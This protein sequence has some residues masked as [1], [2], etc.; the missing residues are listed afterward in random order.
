MALDLMQQN[1]VIECFLQEFDSIFHWCVF[2]LKVLLAVLSIVKLLELWFP[3]GQ[4]SSLQSSK[5]STEVLTL[6]LQWILKILYVILSLI[7]RFE[8][9]QRTL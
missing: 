6:H 9:I 8:N 2:Y 4:Y 7:L 5:V 1:L 3:V